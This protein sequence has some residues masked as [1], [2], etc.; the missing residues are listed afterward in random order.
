MTARFSHIGI[1]VED[2]DAAVACWTALGA[3]PAGE[4]RLETMKLRVVFLELGGATLELIASEAADTPIAKFLGKR[5]PGLHHVAFQVPDIEAALRE[6]E[7]AGL[8][9]VDRTPRDG[10]HRMHVAFLHPEAAAGVLV[11]YCQPRRGDS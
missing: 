10:A 3:T 6:A 1:A 2:M 9:L 4:E 5:G 11:E 7:A 8:K